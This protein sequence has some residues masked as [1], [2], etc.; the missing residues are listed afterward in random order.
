ML[1]PF[2][3][4]RPIQATPCLGDLDHPLDLKLVEAVA[5]EGIEPE[6]RMSKHAVRVLME[7]TGGNQPVSVAVG[8]RLLHVVGH[9]D[10]LPVTAE[11][12]DATE[13]WRFA[14]R[15]GGW[16]G[17]VCGWGRGYSDGRKAGGAC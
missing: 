8:P 9:Y 13:L 4:F 15:F 11:H 3:V 7:G 6:L 5:D 17:A 2:N 16:R 14:R 10:G 1:V 12:T